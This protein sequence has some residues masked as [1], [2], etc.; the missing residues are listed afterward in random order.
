MT[1]TCR[2]LL[3]S[4]SLRRASTNAAVLRTAGALAP[5]GVHAVLPELLAELPPFNPDDEAEPLH[6][7]VARLRQEIRTSDALLISTPEYAGALPGSFKNLLDWTIGDGQRG[8]IYEKPVAWI[9]ASPRGAVLAH[10]SLRTVLGYAKAEIVGAACAD[11]PVTGAMIGADG[12]IIPGPVRQQIVAALAT[13]AAGG[14]PPAMA[15]DTP[16]PPLWVISILVTGDEEGVRAVS[17]EGAIKSILWEL[18]RGAQPVTSRFARFRDLSASEQAQWHQ[19]LQR[20]AD[21]W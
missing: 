18:W 15:S 17:A 10:Q 12:L 2:V 21:A 8:S 9:N 7:A 19:Q 1:A 11:I 20:E 3:L 6:P 14:R 4:G 16:D 13:L 5:V